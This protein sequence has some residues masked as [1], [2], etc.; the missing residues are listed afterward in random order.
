MRVLLL[1][2][3]LSH[4]LSPRF[5]NAAFR[6]VGLPHKYEPH[7][8]AELDVA[9]TR[10]LLLDPDVLGAN[11]TVP[12]KEAVLP[13]ADELTAEA[14]RVGAV[15]TFYKTA[16]GRLI[17]HNT[18]LDGFL[19]HLAELRV[20]ARPR[21]A[22]VIG[23][24]GAA[25]AVVAGLAP[26]VDR[27]LLVNRGLERAVAL[28]DEV[29]PGSPC[30]AALPWPSDDVPD[31]MELAFARAEVVVDATS[32]GQGQTPGTAPFDEALRSWAAL[33]WAALQPGTLCYDLKYAPTSPFLE[34]AREHGGRPQN[35]LGMLLHQ[36]ALAFTCWTGLPAPL[37]VM[38]AAL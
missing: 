14:R 1:G 32:L 5:Q 3:P 16:A 33:P 12:H 22:V 38:R 26:R 9:E 19:A 7:P 36:G 30:V 35:G 24:G 31:D 29:A 4:S 13:V 10:A 21:A 23:A 18:D 20:P 2:F 11:V 34:L 15:N 27:L 8:V 37:E 17:G 28:L 25:R 6:A